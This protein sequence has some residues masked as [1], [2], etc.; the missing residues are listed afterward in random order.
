[1]HGGTVESPGVA[2]AVAGDAGT[3]GRHRAR[4]RELLPHAGLAARLRRA[5]RRPGEHRRHRHRRPA[6]GHHRRAGRRA[7]C[8]PPASGRP[9][10]SRSGW[11]RWVRRPRSTRSTT[12]CS[13]CRR[14]R[15][16]GA[17]ASPSSPCWARRW[18][19]RWRRPSGGVRR[20][21]ST[22]WRS[23]CPTWS[24]C[25]SGVALVLDGHA[26]WLAWLA[27]SPLLGLVPGP[28]PGPRDASAGGPGAGRGGA[29]R[30]DGGARAV[31]RAVRRHPRRRR[32]GHLPADRASRRGAGDGG[33]AAV[34]AHRGDHAVAGRPARR[35]ARQPPAHA[36]G[37]LPGGGRAGRRG[38]R[39]GRRGRVGARRVRRSSAPASARCRT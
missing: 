27:A 5:G 18:P 3:G 22:G 6:G 33:A 38:R 26:G 34:R 7:R 20:S 14:S 35:P 36:A 1:M 2:V 21:G 30:G 32:A 16:S 17:W 24:R 10:C 12:G 4:V 15:R 29:D 9:G 13:G 37:A 39:A 23:R 11:S 8:S 28:D 25:P 19:R 31:G